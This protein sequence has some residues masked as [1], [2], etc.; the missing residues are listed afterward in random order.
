MTL[1]FL[2][3]SFGRKEDYHL[4][5]YHTNTIQYIWD[6]HISIE[7]LMCLRMNVCVV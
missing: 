2:E 5:P 3:R 4:Y 7:T 1:P 6:H